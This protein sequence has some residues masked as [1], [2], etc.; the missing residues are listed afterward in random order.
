MKLLSTF[1]I[2]IIVFCASLYGANELITWVLS[3]LPQSAH[4]WIGIL[5]IIIW[6]LC[7]VTITG[8][9]FAISTLV[10]GFIFAFLDSFN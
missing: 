2:G 8:I 3:Q 1:I 4:E 7:F 9:S 10:A 6:I 5:R